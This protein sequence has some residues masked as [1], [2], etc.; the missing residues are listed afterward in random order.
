MD[1][2]AADNALKEQEDLAVQ[3]Q[4]RLCA[5]PAI[6]PLNG[7]EG[8]AAKFA[9]LETILGELGFPPGLRVDAPDP[10][11]AGGVRP[12]LAVRLPGRRPALW[13]LSHVDVVPPG[14]ESLW[15]TP[16]WEATRDGDRLYGRG[17]EDNQQ[18][19]VSS[20]LAA[21]AAADHGGPGRE[22]GLLFVS[23]EETG[24]GLGLAHVLEAAPD[25]IRP[26][27]LV[28]VPDV[29]NEDGTLLEVA[30]KSILW[31]RLVVEGVQCHGS[32]PRLGKN[33]AVAG[34]DLLLRLNEALP[35]RFSARDDLFT[36]PTSTFVPSRREENQPNINMVPGRDVFHL[37]CRLLPGLALEEVEE[38]CREIGDIVAAIHGVSIT[39]ERAMGQAAAPPTPVDAPIVVALQNAIRE[40]TGLEA[41]PQ[42][43]GGGTV[44]AIFRE[45]DI[46]AAVWSTLC[47]QAHQPNEYCLLPNLISDA[48]VMLRLMA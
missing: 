23:D 1:F 37:D 17:T 25:L 10:R 3:I 47:W 6:G 43:V 42:G 22:V 31:L 21:K 28:L 45:R 5:V 34:S 30:E 13:I 35:A 15:R 16:P 18:G 7:G 33:A 40:V 12:N 46:P 4:S 32:T 20:I 26:D 8:E 14:D 27:D 39:V 9:V 38:A 29:G 24:S 44:A 48:R 2:T 11:V 36:P 41:K 19:L